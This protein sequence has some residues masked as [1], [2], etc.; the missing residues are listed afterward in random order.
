MKANPTFEKA[1][2]LL[3]HP[4]CLAALGLL[5]LNDHLF[6]RYWPSWWTGKI[7]DATWLLF[8]PFALAAALAWLLP[9]REP[10]RRR[11]VFPLAFGLVGLTFGLLKVFP[12]LMSMAMRIGSAALQT[13]LATR[14]DPSDLLALPALA[15]GVYLWRAA[16][17]RPPRYTAGLVALPLAAL[18][19]LANA[20]M[21]DPGIVCLA[22][23]EGLLVASAGYTTFT[24]QD[25]GQT[26][27]TAQ[28]GASFDCQSEPYP[29]DQW[30]EVPGSTENIR[31]RFM[32]GQAIQI[33]T[34]AG[35]DWQPGYDFSAVSEAKEIYYIKSRSGNP[36]FEPG[37]LDALPDPGSGAMLFAMGHQGV[38]IHHPDGSW[39]WAAVD[40]YHRVEPFPTAD[41]FSLLLGGMLYLAGGLALL[42]YA[43]LALRWTYHALRLT[44]LL[45]A[46]AAWLL[47]T[48][49][50]PPATNYGYTHIIT[51]FGIGAVFLIIVPLVIEQ[52]V[53]LARQAPR[54]LAPLA[55]FGLLGG[56]LF[57]LPYLLWL[58]STLPGF[59][60]ATIF[61]LLIAAAVLAAGRIFLRRRPIDPPGS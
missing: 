59:L 55:A 12:G 57:L 9:L 16:P 8:A 22:H 27:Q 13:P 35:Q 37:P 42:I 60:W 36:V 20:A 46:W 21:P 47:I 33:S 2:A 53:R 54:A 7:G 28:L 14:P 23:Q 48:V 11:W 18:L 30:R 15:L 51:L 24:S 25:G 1:L 56:L 40:G 49:L 39:S 17:D 10:A 45:L 44:F 34:N 3:A 50:F 38:L 26:W 6:R 31:Y 43:S 52:T 19:T 4:A 41:A 32:P 29:E 58:Y 61:A 5:L